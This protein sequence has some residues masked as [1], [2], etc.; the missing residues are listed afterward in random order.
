MSIDDYYPLWLDL[1]HALWVLILLVVPLLFA[2]LWS[3][4][5]LLWGVVIC[6]FVTI[7]YAGTPVVLDMLSDYREKPYLVKRS[8]VMRKKELLMRLNLLETDIS[9]LRRKTLVPVRKEEMV[10]GYTHEEVPTEILRLRKELKILSQTK[11]RL[12]TLMDHLGLEFKTEPERIVIVK[13]AGFIEAVKGLVEQ[14]R[15]RFW[16]YHE[17]DGTTVCDPA[18]EEALAAVEEALT[19]VEKAA[20]EYAE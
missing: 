19:E 5:G 9:G 13:S 12:N 17:A 2:Y 4:K 8:K 3:W 11:D 20:R 6:V 15:D 16:Q 18:V 10:P 7:I 1:V 14:I